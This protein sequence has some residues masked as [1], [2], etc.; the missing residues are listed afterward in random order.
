V[1]YATPEQM[2]KL[3]LHYMPEEKLKFMPIL[4]SKKAMELYLKMKK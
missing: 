3:A 4:D 1:Y 2:I